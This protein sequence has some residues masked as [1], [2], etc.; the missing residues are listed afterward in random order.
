MRHWIR[1]SM[2]LLA[3]V[4]LTG[5]SF[6]ARRQQAGALVELKGNYLYQVDL[7]H[8]TAG[9]HG[10]DSARIA[11]DYIRQWASDILLYDKAAAHA[12]SALETLVAEYRRSL[13]VHAYQQEYIAQHM[14][15]AIP[16]S[17]VQ[18]FYQTHQNRYILQ[19]SIVRGLLIIVPNG[20]P[21]M[22]KLRTWL[23]NLTDDNME[24]IEKYAYRYAG[25]YELFTDRWCTAEQLLA[26]IPFEQNTLDGLLRR[27]DQIT[28]QDSVSTFI[29]QVT[30]KR[31][32]GEPMPLDFILPD[33]EKTLLQQRQTE[34]LERQRTEL[35]QQAIRY[36]N[37]RFYEKQYDE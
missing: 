16:D 12:D 33:I 34:W 15:T 24:N 35:Y 4:C 20:A 28:V 3:A 21:D 10:D 1:Y 11:N 7:D 37:I 17:V 6:F 9:L 36:N 23:Q 31:L 29:L 30:D 25:G 2:V 19:E 5:C 32:T 14:P 18:D 8:I 27:N 22:K 13:Y 26:R